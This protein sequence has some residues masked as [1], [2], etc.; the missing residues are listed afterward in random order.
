MCKMGF[1]KEAVDDFLC[2]RSLV[3]GV[4]HVSIYR[5]GN[6][7]TDS[8]LLC[9]TSKH[10]PMASRITSAPVWTLKISTKKKQLSKGQTLNDKSHQIPF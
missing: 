3:S 8:D 4:R 5:T 2:C 10:S 9:G 6:E 1:I 7:C